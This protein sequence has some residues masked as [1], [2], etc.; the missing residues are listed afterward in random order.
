[1]WDP[2]TEELDATR[3]MDRS[4]PARALSLLAAAALLAAG[5]C[6]R[7]A[8]TPPEPPPVDAAVAACPPPAPLVVVP[9]ECPLEAADPAGRA[10]DAR[11]TTGRD[12]LTLVAARF[13]DL[14]GWADDRHAEAVPPLLRSC[15]EL[16]KLADGAPIGS[17]PYG[18]RARDWRRLC[19]AAAAVP[20]GDHAAARAMFER[21]LRP[22]AARG[23]DGFDGKMTAYYVQPLDGARARG[24]RY[25]FPIYARP[26]DLV[27][28]Q[29]S[30]FISDGR[31]RRIWGRLDPAT[32][33]LVRYPTRAEIAASLDQ[34]HV[35][36]WLDDPVDVLAVEVEGSGKVSL[37][38]GGQVWINFAGKNGRRSP[39]AGALMRALRQ[40]AA[41]PLGVAAGAAAAA[42]AAYR[43][44]ARQI[45]DVKD[46]IVFFEV[47][48]RAAAIGTQEVALTPRRSLAVDRAVIPLSTPIWITTRIPARPGEPAGPWQRLLIAQDTGGGILGTVRA[49][50]YFGDDAEAVALGSKVN[51]PGRMWLLLPAGL[52]VRSR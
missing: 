9:A 16:A 26:P 22:Y 50:I 19:A 25:Q 13:A 48:P 6:R 23:R 30:D 17:G 35:L 1:M 31:S 45:I 38:D 24:G 42:T 33:A 27:E 41:S 4:T 49:D 39:G 51:T 11:S 36:F 7:P 44:R 2:Q 52:A 40:L 47:E 15:G 12:V 8:R 32:G 3:T 18:G 14:P 28:V 29:L 21:E 43:A 46:S 37:P 5:A 10:D 20:P 34:D